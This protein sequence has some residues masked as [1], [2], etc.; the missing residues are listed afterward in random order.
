LT[1]IR[2]LAK[3]NGSVTHFSVSPSGVGRTATATNGV[4]RTA[5]GAPIFVTPI[6]NGKANNGLPTPSRTTSNKTSTSTKLG[7][8]HSGSISDSEEAELTEESD[9]D[10]FPEDVSTFF[11]TPQKT[12]DKMRLR[13]VPPKKYAVDGE[14]ELGDVGSDDSDFNP[15]AEREQRERKARRRRGIVGDS[16]DEC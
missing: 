8:R 2:E 1:K 13:A 7:K 12:S 5:A 15:N 9:F 14:E 3:K 10:D 16:S 6:K 11:K 4:N